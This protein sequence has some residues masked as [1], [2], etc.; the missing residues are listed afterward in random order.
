VVLGEAVRAVLEEFL[1]GTLAAFDKGPVQRGET[2]VVG[3]VD[4]CAPSQ[5]Q[6]NAR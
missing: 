4:V 5:K 6:V 3:R 2:L 1:Y